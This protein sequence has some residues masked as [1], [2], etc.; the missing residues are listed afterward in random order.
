MNPLKMG[1]R[2]LAATSWP[3][4]TPS[5]CMLE[6]RVRRTCWRELPGWG[7]VVEDQKKLQ[8]MDGRDYPVGT[9][10][11]WGGEDRI[12]VLLNGRIRLIFN[13]TG[14]TV[15]RSLIMFDLIFI[16]TWKYSS[17]LP[18]PTVSNINLEVTL[19]KNLTFCG[20]GWGK[21]LYMIWMIL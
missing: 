18:E 8:K 16:K 21:R 4:M 3:R 12:F 7:V 15:Y 6:A 20:W 19:T 14:C 17:P 1:T 9:K 13:T 2:S 5:S 10:T 11:G